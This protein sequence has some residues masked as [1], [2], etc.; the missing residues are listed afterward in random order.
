MRSHRL[1]IPAA[2]MTAILCLA[3]AVLGQAGRAC[4]GS[5]NSFE[6]CPSRVRAVGDPLQPILWSWRAY[7]L[8]ILSTSQIHRPLLDVGRVCSQIAGSGS[9]WSPYYYALPRK[10]YSSA[11]ARPSHASAFS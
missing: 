6:V 10:N 4:N 7:R 2:V 5:D 9:S 1:A 8:P 11:F 3:T